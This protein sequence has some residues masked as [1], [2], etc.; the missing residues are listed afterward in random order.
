[1]RRPLIGPN[2]A[3]GGFELRLPPLL[4]QRL[5]TMAPEAAEAASIA[6]HTALLS[7]ARLTQQ[8]GRAALVALPGRLLDRPEIGRAHV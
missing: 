8:P 5:A 4:E 3:L 6:H 2:G 7:T 1:M